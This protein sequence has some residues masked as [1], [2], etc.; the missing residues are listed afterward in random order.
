[1]R[2]TN[3]DPRMGAFDAVMFG[4]E[5][6]PLLRSVITLV[7][8]L[9]VE[10]DPEIIAD[11]V[12]RMSLTTPKLRQRAIGNPLSLVPP[13]WETDPNFDMAYH[14]RWQRAPEKAA[15]LSEVLE[16]AE[17][18]SE[19]DFD[20]S[21][22][23][24]EIHMVTGLVGG[25][26]A[27]IIKIHHAI[28]DGMGGLAM[29]AA[30]FDLER[31]PTAEL[32]PKPAAPIGHVLDAKDRIEQGIQVE[33]KSTFS[34]VKT[35]TRTLAGLAKRGVTDPM[36]TA[37]DAQEFAAS[38]GRLLAP[39]SEPL[40]GLWTNRSLSVAFSVIEVDLDD[41]KKAAKAVGGTLNDAFMAS[42]TGGLAAYHELHGKNPGALRVNMPINVRNANDTG[43]SGNQWV[44]ARFIVPTNIAD[45]AA[46]MRQLHPILT[47]AR[48]EPALPVSQVVYKALALLPRP[49]TT[50]IAGGLMKGTD[51]AATNVPG[52]PIP[53]YIA[54]SKVESMI[55]FAPKAGAAINIGLMSYD[56]KIFLGINIDRGAVAYPEELTD[57]LAESL[58]SVV[59][60][61]A[62]T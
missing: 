61:G 6:D 20:R 28:T 48:M 18:I 2:V 56:G 30:L 23:L 62:D 37:V 26:A 3:I 21:R 41:L 16:L 7:T 32:P 44:P 34:D 31:T 13:R 15:G 36:T 14:L 9:D 29:A 40:S 59:A 60:V 47:Q 33:I 51:F 35:T 54:G 55:P 53:I 39:A 11:R 42:V 5:G 8:M 25:K 45:A 57:L 52:P 24:W 58:E 38:A 17:T 4:V 22:P 43:A 10:P 19:Q 27:F 1:V 49:I 50:S 46:R 12:D